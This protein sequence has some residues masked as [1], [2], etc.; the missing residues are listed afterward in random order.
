MTYEQEAELYARLD[1][2]KKRLTEE[3][4]FIW[5]LGEPTGE[6]FEIAPIRA[7][8]NVHQLLGGEAFAWMLSLLAGAWQGTPNSLKASMLSG[9]AL[10][11][12]AYETELHDRAFIRRMSIVSPEEIIRLGRIETDVGLRF[13]RIILDK[14]NGGGRSCPT[15]SN[16]DV[17]PYIAPQTG[18]QFAGLF[19]IWNMDR[20]YKHSLS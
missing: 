17:P 4:G 5:A 1:R 12:K 10:F 3:V 9:M 11:V 19:L 15:A 2:D 8:I 20:P 16:A 18:K 7:L 13:A 14:Y 6:P